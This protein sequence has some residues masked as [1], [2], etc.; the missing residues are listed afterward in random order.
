MNMP[1]PTGAA[2][3]DRKKNER[4]CNLGLKESLTSVHSMWIY[5]I[6]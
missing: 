4:H 6:Y 5:G 1:L 2:L 3:Y